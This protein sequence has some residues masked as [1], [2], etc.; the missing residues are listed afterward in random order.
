MMRLVISNQK[1]NLMQV[2]IDGLF[3][4]DLDGSQLDDSIHAVKWDGESGEIERKDSATDK[5]V[6]NEPLSSIADFQFA[7]D[8]W[9]AAKVAEESAIALEQAKQEA[10][11][12]AY[13]QA[14]ANGDSEEDATAAGQAA[15]DAVTSA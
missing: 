13:D 7:I 12:L 1:G 8:L 5:M 6:G 14:I 4:S 11:A 10:H 15:A 9:G 3:Y 2:G